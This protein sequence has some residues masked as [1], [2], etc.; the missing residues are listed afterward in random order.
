MSIFGNKLAAAEARNTA[1]VALLGAIGI[2]IK[3]D[4]ELPKADSL[5]AQLNTAKTTAG[6]AAESALL[7]AAGI[8]I[9][10][11]QTATVALIGAIGARDG[12]I[13][14]Y[15]SG[16]EAAGVKLADFATESTLTAEEKKD[17]TPDQIAAAVKA[18]NVA[19]IKEAIGTKSGATAAQIV[20]NAGHGHALETDPALNGGSEPVTVAQLTEAVTAEKDTT[21]KWALFQKLQ[22]AE[23]KAAKGQN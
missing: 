16:L 11:G 12:Q 17:K 18:K 6:T 13:A 9:A 7:K 23:A 1:L 5:I 14:L 2:E 4:G 15:K 22:A 3:A 19:L 21:K 20:A 8:A 10:D